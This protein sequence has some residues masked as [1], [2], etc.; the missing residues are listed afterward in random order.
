MTSD[1]M[2]LIE[3]VAAEPVAAVFVG[4]GISTEAGLPSW[5]SL[6]R[7]LLEKIAPETESFRDLADGGDRD[8]AARRF[9]ERTISA[10]GP[11]GAAAVAKA[12]LGE[13]YEA[14]VSEMLLMDIDI[15][16]LVPGPTALAIAAFVIDSNPSA[17]VL[18]TNYDTLLEKAFSAEL[19]KR[20]LSGSL[21]TSI[22]PGEESPSGAFAI[23]HL[24]GLIDETKL[25]K[26]RVRSE[27]VLAED[28]FFASDESGARRRKV[29][30]EL[31]DLGRCLF[32][33]TSLSD[34]NILGYLYR[35]QQ[36]S[37]G[38]APKHATIAVR[39]VPAGDEVDGIVF[40]ALEETGQQRLAKA[41]VQVAFV[42]SY[43]QASQVVREIDLQS[44]ARAAGRR[45]AYADASWRY[46]VRATR[47]E[48]SC[49]R[50]GLL[51]A[52]DRERGFVT[53][54]DRLRKVLDS[55]VVAVKA[56]MAEIP[57]LRSTNEELAIH[58]W[59]FSPTTNLLLL[60]AQ[61]EKLSYNPGIIQG[62]RAEL[63]TSY[64][65][66]DAFCNGTVVEASF[67][68]LR[69]GRWGSMLAVPISCSAPEVKLNIR[70]RLPAGVIVLA[71][72]EQGSTGLSRLRDRSQERSKLL[73]ALAQ[74]GEGI[75]GASIANS[76]KTRARSLE[77]IIPAGIR[78]E[79]HKTRGEPPRVGS[80]THI[81]GAPLEGMDDLDLW[82]AIKHAADSIRSTGWR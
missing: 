50:A 26:A 13:H 44:Q 69:S 17:A 2:Q 57:A 68:D 39:Q 22:S 1:V 32:L 24:H 45:L 19:R 79:R 55:A 37:I 28:E 56:G 59:L 43:S 78:R 64:L 52:R 49:L 73:S 71:S 80:G 34:P 51:P 62:A 66:V 18:T 41:G 6:V 54:Q 61:S 48:Q 5:T 81:S 21:V 75:I 77:L 31:L 20:S 47:F 4:A 7:K 58:L 3:T 29:A 38:D 11:L 25:P 76:P 74:L 36:R 46:D 12:H 82:T 9:A 42:S 14:T 53:T 15:E 72:T 35:A 16:L 10:L 60:S 33:G 40:P 30:D 65:V 8:E 27:L 67:P 23:I 70:T 63:P